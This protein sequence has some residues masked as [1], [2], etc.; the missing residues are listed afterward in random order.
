MNERTTTTTDAR[1]ALEASTRSWM[2]AGLVL[3]ALF[4]LAFPLFRFYE[5]ARRADARTLQEQYLADQ[6][7]EIYAANCESCHGT[8]GTGAVAPAIGSVE[9]LLS[10]DDTQIEQ[11]ISVGVPGTEM[12]AYSL[13]YGGL[14]T[15]A[16]VDAV[17]TYLRSLEARE[18]SLA[19][20]RSPLENENLTGEQL[21]LLAC[22]RCHGVDRMGDVEQG[23]PSL[24]A[25]SPAMESADVF[26]MMRITDGYKLMPRFGRILS[27]DQITSIV[28]YLRG[29][30]TPPDTTTTTTTTTVPGGS[31]T[32]TV[33][34]DTTTTTA[35]ERTPE[36]DPILALGKLVWEET[37]GGEGCQFCHGIDAMGTSDAPPVVGSGRTKIATAL[38]GGVVDMNFDVKLTSEEIDAVA[39]YLTYLVANPIE[40]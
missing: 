36:N 15:S 20:W 10:V 12:V 27:E 18:F 40:P 29:G 5:P 9:F 7:A 39:E 16:E 26:L 8:E 23:I 22:T 28:A 14:L 25:G 37:A 38:A 24:A 30:G 34:T 13:D 11:L 2:L 4:V 35:G 1:A 31:T 33:P 19:N 17:T 3:M 6:G 21:Y 32:T